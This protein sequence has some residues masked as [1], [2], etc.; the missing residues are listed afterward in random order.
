M[1]RIANRRDLTSYFSGLDPAVLPLAK[2]TK[3]EALSRLKPS[4]VLVEFNDEKGAQ[5]TLPSTIIVHEAELEDFFAW[6]TT[7][8]ESLRP[9][10]SF[11][12]VVSRVDAAT[13]RARPNFSEREL[14]ALIGAVLID[15]LLQS[16]ARGKVPDSILPATLRT[17]SA[18]FFQTIDAGSSRVQIADASGLW[19]NTRAAL[20]A[21]DMPF[22]VEHVISFWALV[23]PAFRSE[24]FAQNTVLAALTRYLKLGSKVNPWPKNMFTSALDLER[25]REL[26]REDRLREADE[27]LSALAQSDLDLEVRGAMAG[28]VLSLVSDGDFSLWPTVI[29]ATRIPTAPLWFGIFA[30]ASDRSDVFEFNQSIGRRI[31]QMLLHRS[32]D[33]DLDARELAISRRLRQSSPLDFPLSNVNVLKAALAVDVYG[34]FSIRDQQSSQSRDSRRPP[35]ASMRDIQEARFH[36]ERLLTILASMLTPQSQRGQLQRELD[37]RP[38]TQKPA[39]PYRRKRKS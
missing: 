4:E 38:S 25:F 3:D 37:L 13:Q 22:S 28:Y 24:A 34:W 9:F 19:I 23:S 11:I 2:T 6:V 1:L 12:R 26:S 36:A 20:N 35:E 7:Y 8:V 27:A 30:G 18:V 10:T 39:V 29:E 15:G 31:R 16:K 33:V 5:G 32:D 21:G 14:G 17:L